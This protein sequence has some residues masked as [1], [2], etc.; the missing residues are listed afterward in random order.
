M[1]LNKGKNNA[2]WG[3]TPPTPS[4]VVDPPPFSK[5][6]EYALMD[7]SWF[8]ETQNSFLY[9]RQAWNFIMLPA[10][11]YFFCLAKM[12]SNLRQRESLNTKKNGVGDKAHLLMLLKF[13]QIGKNSCIHWLNSVSFQDGESMYSSNT[14]KFLSFFKIN[15]PLCFLMMEIHVLSQVI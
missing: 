12:I 4:T 11:F 15:L 3:W 13:V 5:I 6:F 1:L 8:H 14:A 7:W 9:F 2:F 10:L